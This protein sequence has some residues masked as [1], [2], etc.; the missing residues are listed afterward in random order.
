MKRSLVNLA[1]LATLGE[2]QSAGP[3]IFGKADLRTSM[4]MAPRLTAKQLAEGMRATFERL[5]AADTKISHR[6][7]AATEQ[8][9]RA[10][11]LADTVRLGLRGQEDFGHPMAR[12]FIVPPA[13]VPYVRATP[14]MYGIGPLDKVYEL[15]R[16]DGKAQPVQCYPNPK[17]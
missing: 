9:R 2:G 4:V 13:Y 14:A 10:I 11:V 1:A 5:E 12:T 15:A 17:E 8:M 3:S 16:L 6:E 7:A